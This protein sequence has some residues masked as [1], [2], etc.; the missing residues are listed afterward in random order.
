LTVK[1]LNTGLWHVDIRPEG[2]T[3]KR[4]RRS[5]DSKAEAQRF[6]THIKSQADRGEWNPKPNDSRPLSKLV[7]L[8][9]TAQGQLLRDGERRT[10]NLNKACERLGNPTAKTLTP[11][12][13]LKY[14]EKRI[15]D[16]ISH[17][18]CNNELGYLSAVYNELERLQEIDYSNPLKTVKAIKIRQTEL[19][20]LTLDQIDELLNSIKTHSINP[21]LELITRICLSTGAR[22]GEAESLT[23]SQVANN[24]ITYTDT[25]NGK[26]RTV[27]ISVELSEAIHQHGTGKLFSSADSA[28]KRAI[29]RTAVQLPKGQSTHVLRH[30]FASHFIMNGGNILTLQRILGHHS[31]AVTMRYAHLAP[32]HLEEA[33]R[34]N[35][36]PQFVHINNV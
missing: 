11:Q 16:G 33:V 10:A 35:P 2:R 7:E 34:L 5:F 36:C 26:N 3:G 12:N 13:Y 24:R 8:W 15:A 29:K 19:S 17:K 4:V 30:T 1:K 9:H 27:P 18:T 22:W 21:H 6:E 14:R 23:S 32:E 31:V 20:Y 28:F 25:K